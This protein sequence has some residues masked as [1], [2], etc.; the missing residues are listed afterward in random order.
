VVCDHENSKSDIE[1]RPPTVQSLVT[2]NIYVPEA[3]VS[4]PEHGTY[5]GDIL[6]DSLSRSDTKP[7]P[8][9]ALHTVFDKYQA[10]TAQVAH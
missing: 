4:Y 6:R 8:E 7:H 10:S 3:S 2:S 5:T 1:S 9:H